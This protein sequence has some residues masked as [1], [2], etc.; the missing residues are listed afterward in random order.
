MTVFDGYAS[1]YDLL[2]RDKDYEAE[3]R[4][5]HEVIQRYHP[6]ART[7]LEMGCGTG[8]HAAA[9]A[10]MGYS[11]HGIDQS[12][13]ML[14]RAARQM[15]DLPAEAAS[16]LKFTQGDIRQTRIESGFDAVIA[17]FHV[18]SYLTDAADLKSTLTN[19]HRH[20]NP[21][22]ILLFDCW[23]GPAVL[24]IGPS[25]RIKRM[26]DEEVDIVRIAE[27]VVHADKN[28][29]DVHYEVSVRRRDT[30]VADILREVH[31]MRYFF[32]P[33]IEEFMEKFEL[34]SV[35]CFE[36]MTGKPASSSSWSVGFVGRR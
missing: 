16:R 13:I 9:L 1:Y 36:W 32:K 2:Y 6:A 18:F 21:G 8:R 35:D 34:Q 25:V 22:G 5:V 19:V 31:C 12:R 3:S 26:S 20:L 28:T 11:V 23:Y 17:L 7:L 27:P 15:D 30:G 14:D 10:R 29:V 33:E 24:T 4:H